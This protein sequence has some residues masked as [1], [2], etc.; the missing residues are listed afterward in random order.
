MDAMTALAGH[1]YDGGPHWWFFFFPLGFFV[2][3]VLAIL[4]LRRVFWGRGPGPWAHRGWP[5]G[6]PGAEQTLATRF[7]S[8]DIDEVEYRARLEVLRAS[9]PG[10]R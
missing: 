3:W 2:F 9:P 4:L 6:A 1:P 8:G 5:S 7:A 10:P